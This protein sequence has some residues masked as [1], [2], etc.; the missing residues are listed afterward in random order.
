MKSVGGVGEHLH[1][2]FLQV[3]FLLNIALDPFLVINFVS[4]L[5]N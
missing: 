4:T 1:I 3:V 5:Q 2:Y